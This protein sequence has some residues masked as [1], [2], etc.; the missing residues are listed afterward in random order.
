M[1]RIGAGRECV[2]GW[3]VARRVSIM[4]VVMIVVWVAACLW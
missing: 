3:R 4:D 1:S 2:M